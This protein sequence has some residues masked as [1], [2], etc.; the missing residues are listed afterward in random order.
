MAVESKRRVNFDAPVDLV[1]EFEEVASAGERT[2]SGELRELMKRRVA[3]HKASQEDREP[4]TS[5]EAS[6]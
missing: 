2:V 1:C 4:A 5:V 3:E 6:A